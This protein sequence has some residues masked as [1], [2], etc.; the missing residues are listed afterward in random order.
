MASGRPSSRRQNLGHGE[1]VVLGQ[2]EV[3]ADGPGSIDE[4]LYRGQRGQLLDRRAG[5]KRGHR[6][7]AHGVL[8]LGAQAKHGAARG[9]HLELDAAGQELVELRP[10]T[11]DLLEVV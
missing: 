6:Q 9:E 4:Q 5:R 7:G 8:A 3:A 2:G 11:D 1:H 10:H